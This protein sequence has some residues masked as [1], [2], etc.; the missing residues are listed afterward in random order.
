MAFFN[1]FPHT[2]NYDSDL[3]WLIESVRKLMECCETMTDW[4]ADQEEAYKEIKE[5]YERLISGNLPEG[6]TTALIKWMQNNAP[7][8]IGELIKMVFFGLTDS[9]YFIAYIPESWEDIIFNTTG[10]DVDITGFDYGHLTL[11]Y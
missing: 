8:I 5:I 1:E 3:G 4:K 6:I 9:G 10:Y 2:R 7:D 11:S